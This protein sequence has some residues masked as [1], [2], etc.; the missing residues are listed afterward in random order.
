MHENNFNWASTAVGFLLVL[1][2]L[3]MMLFSL[4]NIGFSKLASDRM[5][6]LALS[7]HVENS[8]TSDGCDVLD[9]EVDQHFLT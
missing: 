8:A 7:L 3:N 6:L 5:V 2:R 9:G 4:L 1:C